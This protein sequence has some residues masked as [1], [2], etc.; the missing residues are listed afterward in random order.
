M[1][2]YAAEKGFEWKARNENGL[3]TEWFAFIADKHCMKEGRF[4]FPHLGRLIEDT[5]GKCKTLSSHKAGN[6]N[7]NLCDVLDYPA[8]VS[9]GNFS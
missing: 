1:N 5:K 7:K 3:W 6:M 9:W 2:R 8:T 4:F